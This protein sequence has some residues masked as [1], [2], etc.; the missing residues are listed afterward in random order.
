MGGFA[1]RHR[2]PESS[3]IYGDDTA[4]NVLEF[5]GMAVS[6]LLL[7]EEGQQQPFPCALAL[8]DNT[9]AIGWIHK[10][11]RLPKASVYYRPAKFI[12]RKIAMEAMRWN[13]RICA[14]HLAGEKNEVA[15][16]LSFEGTKRGYSNPLTADCPNDDTLTRR[17][18]DSH[19]QLI[20]QSFRIY[21]LPAEINSFILQTLQIIEES[22]LLNKKSHGP[23]LRE[24][25]KAGE[26]SSS[27]S[28]STTPSSTSFHRRPES[29]LER[30]SSSTYG[31][32]SETT[33]TVLLQSVRKKWLH[34]LCAVPSALWVRR[35]GQV[36]GGAP[37]TSATG[38]PVPEKRLHPE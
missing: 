23:R 7:L 24:L 9:S 15:D 34:R 29:S 18:H 4:N 26:A 1:W 6:V 38:I 21:P 32:T 5:L 17:F 22:L 36:A 31:S 16:A 3:A 19:A 10:T 20:P 33:R 13:T 28:E 35:T 11:G 30:A 12:A 8:G 2:I 25:G 37:C 27:Q 14:Q